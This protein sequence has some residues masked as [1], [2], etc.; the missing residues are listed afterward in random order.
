MVCK[1]S[2][3][4]ET[5]ASCQCSDP[6]GHFFSLTWVARDLLKRCSYRKSDITDYSCRIF[7]VRKVGL[8]LIKPAYTIT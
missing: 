5:L 1:G 8:G 7:G 2:H 4:I 3:F 6:A